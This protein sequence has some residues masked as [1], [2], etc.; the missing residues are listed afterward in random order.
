MKYVVILVLVVL[1]AAACAGGLRRNA[2]DDAVAYLDYA[3]EP[4][5]G[6]T[7]FRLQSW[8]PLSRDRLVLWTGVNEA[9]LVTVWRSCPDL[10]FAHSIHVSSTGSQITTFDHVNVGRDRCQ[11]S[12]IRPIDVRRMKADRA[13]DRASREGS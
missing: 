4:V 12:E 11:I 6:F 9:Y 3:G 8:Q 13:A 5:R 10:Q 1:F 2:D 7:S